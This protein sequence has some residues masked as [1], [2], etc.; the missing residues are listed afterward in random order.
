MRVRRGWVSFSLC[1]HTSSP[2][3]MTRTADSA[4]Y[5]G[6][7]EERA[8]KLFWTRPVVRCPHCVG[9]GGSESWLLPLWVLLWALLRCLQEHWPGSFLTHTLHF[10]PA[11]HSFLSSPHRPILIGL[12]SPSQ[13]IL[14]VGL[15]QIEARFLPNTL[16]GP[17][18]ALT[19]HCPDNL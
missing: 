13:G 16:S 9:S 11:G 12:L 5:M 6:R 1:F 7:R 4:G 18:E 10:P 2:I 8:G 15:N 19:E 14:L 17:Q 3:S